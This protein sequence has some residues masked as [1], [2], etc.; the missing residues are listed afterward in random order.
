[1]SDTNYDI[2]LDRLLELLYESW[3]DDEDKELFRADFFEVTTK[4][5]IVDLLKKGEENG[6]DLEKQIELAA[7]YLKLK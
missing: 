4:G 1:M 6:Y 3:M 5:H 2:I 7:Q